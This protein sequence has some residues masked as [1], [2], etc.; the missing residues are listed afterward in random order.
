MVACLE[1]DI[2]NHVCCVFKVT[3]KLSN[4]DQVIPAGLPPSPL[5]DEPGMPQAPG[6]LESTPAQDEEQALRG[7]SLGLV[8]RLVV[9]L[10]DSQQAREVYVLFCLRVLTSPMQTHTTMTSQ[11]FSGYP[12]SFRVLP[13]TCFSCSLSQVCVASRCFK[14]S[15]ALRGSFHKLAPLLMLRL[16]AFTQPLML[17]CLSPGLYRC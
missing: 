4:L 1:E 14:L 7:D 11:E 9:L 15:R 3:S 2:C 16:T 8:G 13:Y 6:P 10:N 5:D 17:S 12:L